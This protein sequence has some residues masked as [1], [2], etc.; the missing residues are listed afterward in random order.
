MRLVLG[1]CEASQFDWSED[2]AILGGRQAKLKAAH[3]QLSR[4]RAF[5]VRAYPLQTH[6]ML[7]DALP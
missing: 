2:W 4:S 3:T 1:P 7:F 6:E 5:A